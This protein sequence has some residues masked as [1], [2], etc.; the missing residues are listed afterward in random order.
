MTLILKVHFDFLSYFGTKIKILY[1][2]GIYV[3]KEE[4]ILYIVLLHKEGESIEKGGEL[5]M[6]RLSM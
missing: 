1:T 3:I 5:N 2:F 4:K 6:L